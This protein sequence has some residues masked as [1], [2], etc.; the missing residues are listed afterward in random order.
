MATEKEREGINMM[1]T[2]IQGRL[3]SLRRAENVVKKHRKK[4]WTG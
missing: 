2:E 1:Q 3:A 4:E